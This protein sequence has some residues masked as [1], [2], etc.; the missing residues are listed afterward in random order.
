MAYTATSEAA[1]TPP[2]S[3]NTTVIITMSSNMRS[4]SMVVS[5]RDKDAVLVSS[6]IIDSIPERHYRR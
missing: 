4:L 5:P 3:P 2:R 1:S 6:V